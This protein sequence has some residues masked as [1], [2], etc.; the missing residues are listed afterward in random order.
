MTPTTTICLLLL[1]LMPF[2]HGVVVYRLSL[3][4]LS[5]INK[6]ERREM[7]SVR[8]SGDVRCRRSRSDTVHGGL[9]RQKLEEWLQREPGMR[10]RADP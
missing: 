2:C 4:R 6:A 10:G 3:L 1:S 8:L 9:D 7:F 5:V